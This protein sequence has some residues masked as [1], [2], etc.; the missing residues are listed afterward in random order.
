MKLS[1][2]SRPRSVTQALGGGRVKQMAEDIPDT[3]AAA[4]TPLYVQVLDDQLLVLLVVV[5]SV[6]LILSSWP[7]YILILG[8]TI[9]MR[10]NA[11]NPAIA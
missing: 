5:V 10:K 6:P 4:T 9:A 11:R 2:R 1:A 8:F 7:L 3:T